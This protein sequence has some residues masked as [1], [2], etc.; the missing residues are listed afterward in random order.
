V[1]LNIGDYDQRTAL[2]IAVAE[3]QAGVV[4][5]LVAAGA[6]ADAKDRFGT[7]PLDEVLLRDTH[8]ELTRTLTS[9]D[10]YRAQAKDDA[11]LKGLLQGTQG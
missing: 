11:D 6:K 2:H 8:I 5:A 3:K 4:K 9:T 1:D 10:Q 7:T